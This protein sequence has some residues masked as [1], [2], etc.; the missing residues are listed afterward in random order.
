MGPRMC[1]S[2]RGARKLLT[3]ITHVQDP[4]FTLLHYVA[5][6]GH[7]T[8]AEAIEKAT[9]ETMHR[10]ANLARY[11][12]LFLFGAVLLVVLGRWFM[13]CTELRQSFNTPLARLEPQV[14]CKKE[15]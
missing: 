13:L 12:E 8:L 15:P 14:P 10:F 4:G 3:T 6:L 1:G 11:V 7:T 5:M 9:P 2:D